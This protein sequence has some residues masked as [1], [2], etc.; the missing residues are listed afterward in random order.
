MAEEMYD[1]VD[2]ADEL[3]AVL[4]D[5]AAP[6]KGDDGFSDA[7][8]EVSGDD[9]LGEPDELLRAGSPVSC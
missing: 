9:T 2:D 8:T 7:A 5:A 6:F 4:F 1:V 3:R